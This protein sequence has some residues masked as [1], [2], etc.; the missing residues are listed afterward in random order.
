MPARIIP[1]ISGSVEK[2]LMGYSK[3]LTKPRYKHFKDSIV[4]IAEGA[5]SLAGLSRCSGT[6]ERTFWH[7]FNESFF[8]DTVLLQ[9]SASAM[10]NHTET[11]STGSALL[12]LDY[13]SVF[14]TGKGFEWSDWLWNE[15]TDESDQIGHEQV[16]ALEYDPGKDYRKCLGYRRFYHDEALYQTEY[17]RG[18]FEKKPVV[19]SRLLKETKPLTKAQ[20][21][22]VDGEFVNCFLVNRL[23][24]LSFAWTGRIKK[25]LIVT[26]GGEAMALGQLAAKLVK[27]KAVTW[28]KAR[29]RN[30]RIKTFEITVTVSS[31]ADRKVKIAVCKNKKGQLAFIGTSLLNREAS[32]IVKVYGYRWEIEVF[33]K[34]MKQNLSFGDYRMRKVGANTRWQIFTLIT[35]NL[36]ELI[37]KTKLERMV[38]SPNYHWFK[39]VVKKMY[40]VTRITLGITIKILKDLRSGGRELIASLKS[41]LH[42]NKAKFY[43]YNGVNLARL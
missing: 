11:R 31:M 40:S 2:H 36:L 35:A 5:S 14:K 41:I 19:A 1:N 16:I 24:Q 8:D 18:D 12:I 42:L 20:E 10:N 34:D 9:K 23:N 28:K 17:W 13:T 21:V 29:Y 15:E 43:L 25:S 38:V 37:R 4:G 3:L 22:L 30:Q 26:D 33:F 32:E 6:S 39:K 7:F 27:E